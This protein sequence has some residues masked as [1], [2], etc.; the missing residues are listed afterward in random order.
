MRKTNSFRQLSWC[1]GSFLSSGSP[2]VTEIAAQFP[3]KWILLDM[4]HGSF[5]ADNLVEHLRI[6]NH[7]G[8]MAIV[9]VPAIDPVLIGKVL[10][11]G[12]D[13][14]MVP[15]VVTPQQVAACKKAMYYLPEGTRGFS[16]SSRQYAY[17]TNVPT[18][19][20]AMDKPLLFAQIED[21]EA[22]LNAHSIAA[23]GVDVLF[24]GPADLKLSLKHTA[25]PG[26]SFDQSLELVANAAKANK[27]MAGIL[28]RD[29][30]AVN[31]AKALGYSCIAFDSDIAILRRGYENTTKDIYMSLTDEL[32]NVAK[33]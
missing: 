3:F 21:S 31:Q 17:G 24:V 33:D 16:S 18:D 12:A 29:K 1:P 14:I 8:I 11:Q 20:F 7:A 6:L 5:T 4:E 22:V 2:I 19:M 25:P 13:G 9:R 27:T 30:N 15:H 10:D 26:L 23:A 28:A 32:R